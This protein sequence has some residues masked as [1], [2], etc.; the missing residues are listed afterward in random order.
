MD[1]LYGM[2]RKTTTLYPRE[3]KPICTNNCKYVRIMS[4]N[5]KALFVYYNATR[6]SEIVECIE[7]ALKHNEIDV[8]CLQ[9]AF[10]IDLLDQLYKLANRGSLNI[11]HP[12]LSR[13]Y[14]I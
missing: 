3:Y 1:F 12:S 6:V 5:V 11:V 2:W 9:E 8:I 4:Y 13:R 10:E 14:W 7:S